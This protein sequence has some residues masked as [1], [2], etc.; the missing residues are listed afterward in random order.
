M[1]SHKQDLEIANLLHQFDELT[2]EYRIRSW[3]DKS[4]NKSGN[5]MNSP[6][7]QHS[8]PSS[9]S[10]SMGRGHT[11]WTS[12]YGFGEQE[13]PCSPGIKMSA[14]YFPPP[15][16]YFPASPVERYTVQDL[17]AYFPDGKFLHTSFSLVCY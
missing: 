8:M 17:L 1:K 14:N 5:S 16:N 2:T 7:S 10:S 9:G 6:V 12:S 4:P 15:A 11:S 3:L 13:S